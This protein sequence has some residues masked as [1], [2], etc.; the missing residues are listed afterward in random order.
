[1]EL[2]QQNKQLKIQLVAQLV[3]LTNQTTLRLIILGQLRMKMTLDLKLKLLLIKIIQ[4]LEV[5]ED[6][7]LIRTL[8]QIQTKIQAL[9]LD[10]TQAQVQAQT[11]GQIQAQIQAQ[12]QAQTLIK[13]QMQLLKQLSLNLAMM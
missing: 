3:K 1:M 8:I 7:K 9:I 13:I 10:Q 2:S 5:E 4:A 12:T 11:L 6:F